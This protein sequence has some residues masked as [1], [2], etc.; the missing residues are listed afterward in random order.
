MC[1]YD[2]TTWNAI[3]FLKH[4][5]ININ[6]WMII[7]VWNGFQWKNAKSLTT[8]TGRRATACRGVRASSA[9]KR[10][11]SD[12][13]RTPTA[14]TDS[15]TCVPAPSTTVSA[16]VRTLNAISGSASTSLP[17]SAS[18]TGIFPA[19]LIL[20][21]YR[22]IV[23][24][25]GSTTAVG[26]FVWLPVIVV[27]ERR[28]RA[29]LR[30]P[31]PVPWRKRRIFCWWTLIYRTYSTLAKFMKKLLLPTDLLL[32]TEN[33][34]AFVYLRVRAIIFLK[35]ELCTEMNRACEYNF[36]VFLQ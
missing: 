11:T 36:F 34:K 30:N 8:R 29:G 24:S 28:R 25:A 23:P 7:S 33:S 6:L 22:P 3:G 35:N 15:T 9:V 13:W 14:T 18:E 19:L 27:S 26:D 12:V 21:R 2:I 5:W 1:Y 20:S 10:P 4:E 16:I 32:K 17:I 31:F